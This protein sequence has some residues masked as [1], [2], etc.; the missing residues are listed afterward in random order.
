MKLVEFGDISNISRLE[1]KWYTENGRAQLILML[2]R[3]TYDV[4]RAMRS[5]PD[6]MHVRSRTRMYQWIEGDDRGKLPK[7][8]DHVDTDRDYV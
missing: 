8:R 3:A 4:I 2:K 6:M 1:D 7:M 5:E